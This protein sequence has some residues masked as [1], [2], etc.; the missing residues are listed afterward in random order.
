MI[1]VDGANILVRG[2][3]NTSAARLKEQFDAL[4]E[5]PET[6]DIVIV[7]QLE[8]TFVP[9]EGSWDFDM[10]WVPEGVKLVLAGDYHDPV[11]SGRLWYTGSTY[12]TNITEFAQ[13]SCLDVTYEPNAGV[14]GVRRVP[15]MKRDVREYTVVVD[16]HLAETVQDIDGLLHSDSAPEAI[17]RPLVFVKYSTNVKGALPALEEACQRGNHILRTKVL[18][19]GV[20]VVGEIEKPQGDV[21]LEACLGQVVNREEDEEFHSFA[22]ALLKSK[23]PADVLTETKAYL[24]VS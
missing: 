18:A 10:S 17:R 14:F 13:R 7:H 9:Y 24:G 19:G 11:Q 16:D 20:E 1:E 3:D 15:L 6:P 23:R 22:L 5:F 21:T 8:K 4:R 2:Y 12:S